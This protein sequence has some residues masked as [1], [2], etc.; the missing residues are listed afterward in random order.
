[1][2]HSFAE[3]LCSSTGMPSAALHPATLLLL[4]ICLQVMTS[5]PRMAA[6]P[7]R[8][9]GASYS[10]DN[11]AAMLS[12]LTPEARTLVLAGMAPSQRWRIM[13]AMKD[14]ERAEIVIAMGLDLRKDAAAALD[15]KTW[16]RTIDVVK[17]NGNFASRYV[18]Y[19]C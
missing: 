7:G 19:W 15:P 1:M 12:V 2:R 3:R 18:V 13:E 10:S 5:G 6:P 8:G 4:L 16:E 11:G 14:E 9:Q 17:N